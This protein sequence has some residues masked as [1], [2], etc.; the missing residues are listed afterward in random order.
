MFS[1]VQQK[2]SYNNLIYLYNKGDTF[3]SQ[4]LAYI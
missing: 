3:W 2:T 4:M 1:F